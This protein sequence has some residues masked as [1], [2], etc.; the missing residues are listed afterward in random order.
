MN[1]QQIQKQAEHIAGIADLLTRAKDRAKNCQQWGFIDPDTK[2]A[3]KTESDTHYEKRKQFA[4][5]VAKR[6][7]RYLAYSIDKL[8]QYT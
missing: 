1:P 5:D 4:H 3:F 2:R 8:T 7:E 6:I